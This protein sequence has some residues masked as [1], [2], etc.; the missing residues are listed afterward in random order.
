MKGC[1]TPRLPRLIRRRG[2]GGGLFYWLGWLV[3]GALLLPLAVFALRLRRLGF[4]EDLQ[5][6]QAIG[7]TSLQAGLAAL[8]SVWLALFG[9]R[10]L[11]AFSR[12]KLYVLIEAGALLP[13]LIPPLILTVSAAN[14][15]ELAFPFPFGFGA[16]VF[17]QAMTYTGLCSAALAR[18][19]LR[20]A[21]GLEEWA[22]VHGASPWLFMKTAAKTILRKDIKTLSVMV[23]AGAFC[24]LSLPLLTAGSP[25][26]SLEFFIYEQLKHPSKWPAAAFLILL[27]AA[28]IF[29]ICLKG[30]APPPESRPLPEGPAKK[31]KMRLLPS[32]YMIVIP[33]IPF[34]MSWG[35]LLFVSDA[36][37]FG[38]LWDLRGFLFPA[39]MA[40][41]ASG[42]G[43]GALVLALLALM[44][45]SFQNTKARKF[46]ASF[47]NPGAA[48][49][50]FAFLL[51]P[52]PYGKP[53]VLAKWILGLSLL[54]FPLLYR[55]RGELALQKLSHQ[56]ETA[57][58]LG[59][60]WGMIFRKILW[61]QSRGVFFLCSGM[62]GFWACGDFSY[63]LIVSQGHWNLALAAHDFFSSYRLDL[64][65]LAAGLL[66]ILSF[67]VLLF[68]AGLGFV[69]DKKPALRHFEKTPRFFSAGGGKL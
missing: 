66:L 33:L 18:A 60:G 24:S 62:A 55:F 15:T 47:V 65:V 58:F 11:L 2:F 56:A 43:A 42:F 64:A 30:F 7:W 49:T 34:F 59:A 14:L 39:A 9:A 37:A 8:I 53:A 48:L 28:F 16:L 45:L 67:F 27:Q 50:G 32:P 44:A 63:S 23:F 21:G 61:P 40:S 12:K 1:K 22:F 3:C 52:L 4:P 46:A 19:A 10:G 41:L 26:F 38:R 20:E 17:F 25:L 54:F 29:W 51:L 6:L 68:W 13:C 69:F 57:R 31:G 36:A 5:F 35:G